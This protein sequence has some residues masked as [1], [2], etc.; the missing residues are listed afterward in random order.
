MIFITKNDII[1]GL[2]KLSDKDLIE[3]IRNSEKRI[4][5]LMLSKHAEISA[6]KIYV[7]FC[8]RTCLES[9]KIKFFQAIYN[10]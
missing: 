1:E 8:L 6:S 2:N 7:V 10:M 4:F 9:I 5:W 3:I